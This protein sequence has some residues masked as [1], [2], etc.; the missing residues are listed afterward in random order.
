MARSGLRMLGW[1]DLSVPVISA[2][3]A[4]RSSMDASGGYPIKYLPLLRIVASRSKLDSRLR[5]N[6]EGVCPLLL[7][8]LYARHSRPSMKLR[9]S[10]GGNDESVA[11]YLTITRTSLEFCK[12]VRLAGAMSPSR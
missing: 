6:D 12:S 4:R 8:A 5:G 1:Q 2:F 7:A 11:L 3:L 9:M 10:F